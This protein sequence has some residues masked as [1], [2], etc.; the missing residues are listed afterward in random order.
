MLSIASSFF[1]RW[2]HSEIT[3]SVIVAC[4]WT[5]LLC[6]PSLGW[7]GCPSHAQVGWS[8]SKCNGNCI[9]EIQERDSTT[10]HSRRLTVPCRGER[11][12]LRLR[13]ILAC[14]S[15]EEKLELDAWHSGIP[16][17]ELSTLHLVSLFTDQVG[18]LIAERFIYRR[19]TVEEFIVILK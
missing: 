8:V 11:Q 15:I 16:R 4:I 2:R 17:N 12:M 19:R 18:L 10:R 7:C 13:V 9:S 5:N 3:C 6:K 1:F 14:A